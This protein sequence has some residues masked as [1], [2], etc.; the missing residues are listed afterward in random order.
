MNR[1]FEI[2]LFSISLIALLSA[3]WILVP[4]PADFIWLFAVAASEWSL[5]IAIWA[6]TAIIPCVYMLASGGGKLNIATLT[7]GSIA[8]MI[9]LYPLI[10]TLSV[11]KQ[12]GVSISFT[13]YFAGLTSKASAPIPSTHAFATSDG[14]ELEFDF[15]TP[16]QSNANNG[17]S[18][19][20]VHGGSWNRGERSDFPQWNAMLAAN[21]Y[22]VFDIDY[23]LSQP[24]Y[25]TATGDVKCGIRWIAEHAA[26]FA[27]SPERIALLGRS[28]GGHLALLAAYS[29]TDDRLPASCGQI[30]P[31]SKIRAV[32]SIYS[33]VE[34]TWSYDNPANEFVIN[35]KQTLANFI[36]GSPHVSDEFRKRYRLASPTSHVNRETP[37]TLIIHGGR[38]QL[39][40]Q[41][42][43][44]FLDQKLSE[45]N[46]E[47]KTVLIPYAQHGFDYNING[48]GSQVTETVL[49]EFLRRHTAESNGI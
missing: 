32:A 21:G 36:G 35:G 34:L 46:I 1:M 39:V 5:W 15:Y 13:R 3:I 40:R 8:F 24:N 23:R 18:V 22:A 28:A 9:S 20:V 17:A 10:S 6:L 49:L 7:L 47:H 16:T 38:D 12:Y 27:I 2:L 26:E 37:P 14:N 4:A 42:N 19:I 48:W 29:E 11:A 41:K 44:D 33:P 25:L 43:M 31:P 45:Y 30:H